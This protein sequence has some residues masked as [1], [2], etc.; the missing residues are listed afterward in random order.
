MSNV[1]AAIGRGQLRLLPER[2]TARRRNFAFY[3]EALQGVPGIS[4]MPEAP[5]GR[6]S[7]W[8]SVIQVDPAEFGATAEDVRLHLQ[9]ARIESR[10]VW[11]PMH[12][13]PVF[14]ECRRVG[15]AVAEHLFR[16]GLCLPSGSSLTEGERLE[17]VETIV[18]TP[19][20]RR[21]WLPG[22]GER[23]RRAAGGRPALA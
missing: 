11:K 18:A 3:K 14:A 17:V 16:H 15:G 9:R 8:L 23:R 7:R 19:R 1:L 6:A 21:T 13:Q 12:V 5:Y 4:F 10:P 2:V 22:V 20:T